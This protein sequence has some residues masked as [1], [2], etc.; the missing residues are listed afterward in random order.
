M[1]HRSADLHFATTS[2]PPPG[3][4]QHQVYGQQ[5]VVDGLSGLTTVQTPHN[6]C[7]PN[8][9]AYNASRVDS[10][11]A[12]PDLFSTPR[13]AS[14]R[15]LSS[16]LSSCA[17]NP[18]YVQNSIVNNAAQ[19]TELSNVP[20][21]A[22]YPSAL[23]PFVAQ[24]VPPRSYTRPFPQVLSFSE[25]S[26][27][28]APPASEN[29]VT[30]LDI[31]NPN[32]SSR[33]LDFQC[34]HPPRQQVP[35]AVTSSASTAPRVNFSVSPP[36]S[37]YVSD[38][39]QA[40]LDMFTARASDA[41]LHPVSSRL[42]HLPKLPPFKPAHPEFWFN[43]VERTFSVCALDDDSRFTCLMNHLHERVDL[44]SDLVKSPPLTDK[45]AT[46]K[47]IILDRV[48]KTRRENVRQLIYEER[49]GDRSPSQ[50]W[51]CL[52]LLVNECDLP[53]DTLTEIWTEKLPLPVQTAISAYEDRPNC[54]RLRAADRAYSALQ[55]ELRAS[56]PGNFAR[57]L[58]HATYTRGRSQKLSHA[59]P[60][61]GATKP[62]SVKLA[63]LPAPPPPCNNSASDPI[64]GSGLH[65]PQ[66]E[67]TTA[68]LYCYYH[69]KFGSQARTCRHPCSYPNA[70]RG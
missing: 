32:L 54:D 53:D 48:S 64:E 50:L 63:A 13:V 21:L 39:Q 1:A 44:I 30:D 38:F 19:Q 34:I 51:R 49:L 55:R 57:T 27:A 33:N 20:T 15:H 59:A 41:N 10:G 4:P 14:A 23:N 7:T 16:T 58:P 46:A 11:F 31:G 12:S 24:S 25:H 2:T 22:S 35:A 66:Q 17:P 29:C 8:H 40:N 67:Q 56:Q 61:T 3:F 28:A 36:A 9:A 42:A 68:D 70:H 43:L 37:A 26:V 45:Y 69:S 60:T 62:T 47:Q 6:V 65:P 52:R 18:C 5:T